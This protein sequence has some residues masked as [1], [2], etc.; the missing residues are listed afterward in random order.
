MDCCGRSWGSRD[1]LGAVFTLINQ[2]PRRKCRQRRHKY[3]VLRYLHASIL[4]YPLPE[5]LVNLPMYD[6]YGPA[7]RYPAP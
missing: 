2:L 5:G 4:L 6:V 1:D 3:G 7:N